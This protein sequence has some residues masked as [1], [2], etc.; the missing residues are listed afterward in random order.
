[1]CY[2]YFESFLDSHFQYIVTFVISHDLEPSF[3]VY[4]EQFSVLKRVL[5]MLCVSQYIVKKKKQDNI[6]TSEQ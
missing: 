2:F 6:I 3:F 1:M 4:S 5:K